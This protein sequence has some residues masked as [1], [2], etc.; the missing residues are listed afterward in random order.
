MGDAQS[1][2]RQY[3]ER[4]P[5][6]VIYT[7]VIDMNDRYETLK[8]G[9]VPEYELD[10]LKNAERVKCIARN[11]IDGHIYRLGIITTR[12][13]DEDRIAAGT[14]KTVKWQ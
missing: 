2:Q 6:P 12:F 11:K 4:I 13:D 1:M 8:G 5:R 14:K 9:P 3:V 10:L 7:E